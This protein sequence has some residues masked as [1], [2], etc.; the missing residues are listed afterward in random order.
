[1]T[2]PERTALQLASTPEPLELV[3]RRVHRLVITV[4]PVI[5]LA[6]CASPT[7]PVSFENSCPSGKVPYATCANRDYVN[8][9]GD[10]VN[11]VGDYVNPVGRDTIRTSE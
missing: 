11:P 2:A 8:P 5:A 7:A 1:V 3:M 6:A 10:Y 4:V 9:V